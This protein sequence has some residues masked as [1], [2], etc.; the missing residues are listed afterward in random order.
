MLL[1]RRN[2]AYGDAIVSELSTLTKQFGILAPTFALTF[3]KKP[4]EKTHM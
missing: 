4:H 3:T 2:L 1:K